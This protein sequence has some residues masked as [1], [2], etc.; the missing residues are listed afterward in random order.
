MQG[1]DAATE[2]AREA[3]EVGEVFDHHVHRPDEVGGAA[4]SIELDA[5]LVQR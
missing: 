4:S 3:G 2:D 1:L 5:K